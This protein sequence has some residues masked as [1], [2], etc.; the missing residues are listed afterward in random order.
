MIRSMTGYGAATLEADGLRAAAT[1]RS[2][3][4]RYL[5]LT[6]HVSRRLQ[7]LEPELKR[8]VQGRIARGRVEASVRA[9]LP[10]EGGEMVLASRP[11]VGALVGVLRALKAEH[12]LAGEVSVAEVARFPGALEVVE[13]EPGLEEPGRTQVLGV[14]ERALDALEQ[15]RLSEG[16]HLRSTLEAILAEVEGAAQRVESEWESAR[17]ARTAALRERTRALADELGLDEGRLYQE[18]VRLVD[19]HDVAEETGR[20]RSHVAQARAALDAHDPCGKRLDFLAQEMAREA[21]TIG[22]KAGAAG[23][24]RDVVRLRADVERF[25]EQVQNVE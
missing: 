7:P 5:D 1:V 25:R 14:L 6:L 3:N 8:L 9:T 13:A 2:L 24:V 16:G 21:N 20:L 11:L 19:R 22:A 4:H 18:I 17:P 15:M 12:G 23:L 10:Q